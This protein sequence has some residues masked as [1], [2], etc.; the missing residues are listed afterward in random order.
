MNIRRVCIHGS[1]TGF[2][3]AKGKVD[4]AHARGA[5]GPVTAKGSPT[6]GSWVYSHSKLLQHVWAKHA[7][8]HMSDDG[9]A[10]P[11]SSVTINVCCPGTVGATDLPVWGEI[12]KTLGCLLPLVGKLLGSRTAAVGSM[13]LMHLAGS[14]AMQGLN[15]RFLDWGY[16]SSKLQVRGPVGLEHYPSQRAV[17]DAKDPGICKQL[18]TETA[19]LT[20]MLRAKYP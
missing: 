12:R 2:L 15:G 10:P 18:F 16:S 19:E 5:D 1:F 6:T 11:G 3:I 14:P 13:P 9:A 7:A 20:A 4:L 8:A 17:S